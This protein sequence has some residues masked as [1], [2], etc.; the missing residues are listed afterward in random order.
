MHKYSVIIP[1]MWC[2]KELPAM[3][4]IYDRLPNIEEVIIIDNKPADRINLPYKKV[5]LYTKGEN[6]YVN[7]AWNWGVQL[8][9]APRIIIANDDIFIPQDKLDELFDKLDKC[10][11]TGM[12]AGPNYTT[13]R[14]AL[15]VRRLT[16]RMHRGYGTFMIMHKKDFVPIPEDLKLWRGDYI[17]YISN[18]PLSINGLGITTDMSVTLKATNTLALAKHDC[19]IWKKY[20]KQYTRCIKWITKGEVNN[21]FKYKCYEKL[22]A[23]LKKYAPNDILELWPD[24]HKICNI[25]TGLGNEVNVCK[26]PWK[27]GK[28][29]IV[30]AMHVFEHI[31]GKEK[32]VFKEAYK[33]ARRYLIIVT[34]SE[35]ILTWSDNLPWDEVIKIDT[36]N[37]YIWKKAP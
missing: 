31:K 37:I 30:I 6:I 28:F 7:P 24:G 8:A 11:K 35:D 19:V 33:V 25:A 34:A 13:S 14:K 2:G 32:K 29:D 27:I 16:G 1:T 26:P 18:V 4:S 20:V 23:I 21:P 3:L 15:S 10:L 5:K 12:M 9:K 22:I 17:Q 36:R